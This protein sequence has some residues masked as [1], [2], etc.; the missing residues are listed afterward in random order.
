MNGELLQLERRFL[1]LPYERLR[2]RNRASERELAASLETHGQQ[3]AIVVVAAATPGHFVVIDGHRRLRALEKLGRDLVSAR[4][5]R[6]SAAEALVEV[7]AHRLAP[8]LSALE[9]GWLVRELIEQ[10]A[11]TPETVAGLVG[12]SVRWV[13]GRLALARRLPTALESLV[14]AGRLSLAAATELVIPVARSYPAA[15]V[16]F[17]Q[18]L[19]KAHLAGNAIATLARLFRRGSLAVRQMLVDDPVR[20]LRAHEEERISAPPALAR[21][22]MHERS[23]L[24]ALEELTRLTRATSV[25][26]EGLS[27]AHGTSA[28]FEVALARAAARLE[29]EQTELQMNLEMLG[30]PRAQQARQGGKS[31]DY[32][33]DA[34]SSVSPA[35]EEELRDPPDRSSA[36]DVAHQRDPDPEQPDDGGASDGARR[37][38]RLPP[39]DDPGIVRGLRG[40]PL[41]GGGGAFREARETD[42]LFNR[43]AVLPGP[44]A[45]RPDPPEPAGR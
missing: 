38:A 7:R 35:P 29:A 3:A 16:D 25:R 39:G 12:R 40:E 10:A 15:A 26:L 34:R 11:Q 4:L 1:E 21:L 32:Q 8:R 6:I 42:P 19:A 41:A 36:R 37:I 23:A 20:L 13:S 30:A 33:G 31:S 24:E 17:G 28:D 5:L 43:D 9:E 45:G 2:P 18:R 27:I 44:Q 14:L 22:D